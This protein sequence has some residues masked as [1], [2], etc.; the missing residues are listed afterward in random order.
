MNLDLGYYLAIFLRRIH[1]FLIISALVTAASLAAAF[2]LP[3]SYDAQ[4]SLLVESSQIPGP[5]APPTVQA[6]ALEQLQ[7]ITQRL[8]TRANLLDIAKKLNVFK[9]LNKMSPD[10]IVLAMRDNTTIVNKAGKEQ[11]TLMTLTFTG[12]TGQIAAGVVNEYVTLILKE[13]VTIRTERA[14]DTLKF[15][16]Q[17]VNSLGVQLDGLS[18]KILDFKNKNKDA[19]PDTLAFRLS[20]QTQ[21]QDRIATA[22]RDFSSLTDQKARLIAIFNSTGQVDTGSGAT[23][24]P[25]AKQ[26]QTLQS[27]LS[28]ALAVYSE[29]NPKVKMLRSQ[30][31][32]QENIVK[33]QVPATTTGTTTPPKSGPASMLD[34][35]IAD[36]DTRIAQA[37]QTKDQTT[38]QLKVLTDTIERTPANQIALDALNRDYANVQQQY[39]TAV[40]RL[41]Q[42]AAG[43]RIEALSKGEKIAVIDAATVPDSPTK[44]N[45]ILIGVGGAVAGILMGIGAIVLMELLNRSVRRPKDLVKAFGITPITTIPYMNTP[46]EMVARRSVFWAMMAVAVIGIPALIYAVHVYYLPLDIILTKIA[47]KVGIRM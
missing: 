45:R 13:N 30:I 10:E 16:Q 46:N 4:A 44:P 39:N 32:Q 2:L 35:Q 26:L 47:A 40:Q 22:E 3:P 1:Y 17:E 18:A 42:A 7:I 33:A 41:S 37:N 11:A 27:Q 15:F 14:E 34:V 20:Q 12:R 29:D 43:E 5:L 8:M 6:A 19:L 24:T 21:L 28:Q 25:E 38:A 36:L 9:D 31:A 23:L